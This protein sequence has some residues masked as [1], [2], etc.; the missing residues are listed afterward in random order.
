MNTIAWCRF[1]ASNSGRRMFSASFLV[2]NPFSE[3]LRADHAG[4]RERAFLV[5]EFPS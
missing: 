2:R 5:G 3:H 4:Q 1:A